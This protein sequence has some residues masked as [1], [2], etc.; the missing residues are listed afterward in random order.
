MVELDQ[1][2]LRCLGSSAQAA[3]ILTIGDALGNQNAAHTLQT[4]DDELSTHR[5]LIWIGD[6]VGLQTGHP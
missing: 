4:R 3:E 6:T 5:N 1:C 2:L